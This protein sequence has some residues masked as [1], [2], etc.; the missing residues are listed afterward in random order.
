[1]YC[2]R[3]TYVGRHRVKDDVCVLGDSINSA[4]TTFMESIENCGGIVDRIISVKEIGNSIGSGTSS[5]KENYT[6]KEDILS[7]IVNAYL[8][9]INGFR[10]LLKK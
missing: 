1:M 9:N 10:D 4:V 8:N 2:Y 7:V 5:C 3:I 6:H